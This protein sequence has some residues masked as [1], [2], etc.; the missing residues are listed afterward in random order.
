[1]PSARKKESSARLMRLKGR[2]RRRPRKLPRRQKQRYWQSSTQ[3]A[4]GGRPR[5][6]RLT[7]RENLT[8]TRP[9]RSLLLL[10]APASAIVMVTVLKARRSLA[11]LVK[12]LV[13]ADIAWRHAPKPALRKLQQSQQ[14]R[15]QRRLQKRNLRFLS[16]P[17]GWMVVR[18]RLLK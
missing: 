11:T 10:V 16:T 9:V 7:A 2:Q 4:N 15:Q 1:M 5:S 8:M 3:A 6:A 18:R 17:N 14:K 12:S 13:V